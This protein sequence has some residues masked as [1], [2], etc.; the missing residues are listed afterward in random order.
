[1]VV[2]TGASPA[3]VEMQLNP[4]GVGTM[5][6]RSGVLPRRGV[7]GAHSCLKQLIFLM[8]VENGWSVRVGGARA[9]DTTRKC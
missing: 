4:Q 2:W 1:M 3:P 6:I 8:E 5:E 7:A 9:L